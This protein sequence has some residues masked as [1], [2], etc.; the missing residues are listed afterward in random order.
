MADKP[1]RLFAGITVWP[2]R[3][4][5][6]VE[7]RTCLEEG[8][9]EQVACTPHTRAHESLVVVEARP[10]EIHAALILAGFAPGLPGRWL[11]EAGEIRVE[12]PSGDPIEVLVRYENTPGHQVE[13]PIRTW[14]QDP[15]GGSFPEEVPWVFAGSLFVPNPEWMGPG[16]HYVADQTGSIIGLVTFGDEVIGLSRVMADQESVQPAEWQVGSGR[17]PPEGTP[18]T[19]ILK[20]PPPPRP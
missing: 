20:R 15:A 12:P 19:L 8:F 18:V 1:A 3:G 11:E 5:V 7:A 4:I 10:S 17:V 13:E 2:K 14:I 16:E 9:L 6:E